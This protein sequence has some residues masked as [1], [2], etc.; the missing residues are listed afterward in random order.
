MIQE[1]LAGLVME[2]EKVSATQGHDDKKVVMARSS[3][4][5]GM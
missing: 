5:Q 3:G 2:R 4:H 1:R